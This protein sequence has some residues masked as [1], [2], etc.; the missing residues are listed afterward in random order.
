MTVISLS[1]CAEPRLRGGRLIP[2]SWIGRATLSLFCLAPRGVCRAARVAPVRGGLLPHHFTLT[3]RRLG[4]D[5]R[6]VFCC[7]FRPGTSRIPV[8]RF[9]EARCPVVSG[10][11]STP[12]AMDE[13]ATVRGAAHNTLPGFAPND[14]PKKFAN[15]LSCWRALPR[16]ASPKRPAFHQLRSLPLLESASSSAMRWFSPAIMNHAKHFWPCPGNRNS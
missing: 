14:N 3:H 13:T 5:G 6:F 15:P 10:L 9:H 8:P 7:T 1:A 2:G 4:D 12:P 11:S 16:A